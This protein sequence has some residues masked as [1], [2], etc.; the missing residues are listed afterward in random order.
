MLEAIPAD[1]EITLGA[2]LS[3]AVFMTTHVA[4]CV[5][6]HASVVSLEV[7]LMGR[8]SV[9]LL[10]APTVV[11]I[12]V[13]VVDG[14]DW[15]RL[16]RWGQHCSGRVEGV[17]PSRMV[18][19]RKREDRYIGPTICNRCWSGERSWSWVDRRIG[20]WIC[21]WGRCRYRCGCRLRS[22]D[23][24]TLIPL[25]TLTSVPLGQ[26]EVTELVAATTPG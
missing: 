23:D 12:V 22:I 9:L 7:V 25:R 16:L 26:T 24:I 10:T 17:R 11:V 5:P 4:G 1:F 6:V 21:D 20:E 14:R 19:R 15:L 3:P 13:A 18:D 8:L 2:A